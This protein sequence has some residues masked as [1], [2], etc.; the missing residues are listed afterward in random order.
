MGLNAP[1]ILQKNKAGSQA[2]NSPAAQ[3]GA[4]ASN[5]GMPNPH[6]DD[7]DEPEQ[8]DQKDSSGQKNEDK[9][10]YRDLENTD[11]KKPQREPQSLQDEMALDAVK[12]GKIKSKKLDIELN[13]PRYKGM[14]K[15][16]A[17]VTSN[18]GKKTVIHYVRDPKTGRMMDFKIVKS[19]F[20]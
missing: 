18:E 9:G 19:S 2:N 5:G 11:G 13:D 17:I 16:Q 3:N 4:A 8:D 7:D 20:F 6:H 12:Q 15:M 1:D 14:D 10:E